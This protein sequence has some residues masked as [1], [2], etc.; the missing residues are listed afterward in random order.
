MFIE[1]WICVSWD[2]I[3]GEGKL[4][5]VD[6]CIRFDAVVEKME[7]VTSQK[8]NSDLAIGR[9]ASCGLGNLLQLHSQFT[10]EDK[11]IYFTVKP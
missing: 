7:V 9:L 2:S 3:G 4:R 10:D 8:A 11:Q 6:L 1:D 5:Y